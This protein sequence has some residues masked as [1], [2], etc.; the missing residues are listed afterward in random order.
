MSLKADSTDESGW[1]RSS[2]SDNL[3]G[4]CVEL[5]ELAGD[6]GVRDS[7]DPGGPKLLLDP[8]TFRALLSDLKRQ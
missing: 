2:H 4:N 5:A 8:P 1:R 6:V 3:G 7:R